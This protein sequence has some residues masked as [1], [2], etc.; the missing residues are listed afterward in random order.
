[1]KLK[2]WFEIFALIIAISAY[3]LYYCYLSINYSYAIIFTESN[4]FI[5]IP[6]IIF[7]VFS[8]PFLVL[9]LKDKIKEGEKCER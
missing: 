7:G 5:R 2:L 3:S 9:F 4:P 8:F 1:M 6:E